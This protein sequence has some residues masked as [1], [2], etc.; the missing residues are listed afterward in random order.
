MSAAETVVHPLALV[1][2]GAQL[3]AGVRIGPFCHIGSDVTLDDGV[4]LVSHV[5]VIGRTTIGAG[6]RVFPH[7]ALGAAPQDLKYKG[8]PTSLTIG[9]NCLLR[10]NFTAHVGTPTG[11]GHTQI[12]DNCFLMAGSHV[13]HDCVIGNNVIMA[14]NSVIGGHCQLADNVIVSGLVALHQFIRIGRGAMLA[15]SSGVA[16]DVIPYG[17]IQGSRST[18]Q[19]LNIIGLR[20]SGASHSEIAELRRAYKMLFDRATPFAE[21]IVRVRDAY[22]Q[23][24]RVAEVLDFVDSREKRSLVF[25][26]MTSGRLEAEGV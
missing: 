2:N 25:P 11:R 9:A 7:V 1:E 6:T 16:G 12:G 4:E 17:L 20:R 10:E 15:G 23:N 22:G 18:L 21:N 8:E 5:S 14:N 26:A 24:A 13:G 3:G 19:G